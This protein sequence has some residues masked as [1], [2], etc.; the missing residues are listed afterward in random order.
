L[1]RSY[2]MFDESNSPWCWWVTIH[3]SRDDFPIHSCWYV[4]RCF[5]AN[6]SVATPFFLW[7]DVFWSELVRVAPLTIRLPRVTSLWVSVALRSRIHAI[8]LFSQLF[9][10]CVVLSAFLNQV[11]LYLAY[12]YSDN[13]IFYWLLKKKLRTS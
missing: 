6:S 9:L 13:Y 7:G 10:S 5:T 2:F 4:L 3:T 8:L 11:G 12:S 1:K